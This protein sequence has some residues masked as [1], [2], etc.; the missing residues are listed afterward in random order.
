MHF[1]IIEVLTNSDEAK[2]LREIKKAEHEDYYNRVHEALCNLYD[3]Y[4]MIEEAPASTDEQKRLVNILDNA[5]T[6]F[7]KLKQAISVSSQS[8]QFQET[9]KKITQKLMTIQD[10]ITKINPEQV[11]PVISSQKT[12][13]SDHSE[14]QYQELLS[15]FSEYI[16][17]L[18]CSTSDQPAIG[19]IDNRMQ[20]TF[21]GIGGKKTI[22]DPENKYVIDLY[23][24]ALN[25]PSIGAAFRIIEAC[26]DWHLHV[27]KETGRDFFN[28]L[29]I[30]FMIIKNKD[31][32]NIDQT[33][34]DIAKIRGVSTDLFSR[35][36]QMLCSIVDIFNFD[37]SAIRERS[38]SSPTATVSPKTP[39]PRERGMTGIFSSLW[40]KP[41]EHKPKAPAPSPKT[42]SFAEKFVLLSTGSTTIRKFLDILRPLEM[43][44]PSDFG[45][46]DMNDCKQAIKN[47]RKIKGTC[48]QVITKHHKYD[49][50]TNPYKSILATTNRLLYGLEEKVNMLTQLQHNALT[51][52]QL[53][54]SSIPEL[55]L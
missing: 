25:K 52:E 14:S 24:T 27:K 21:P 50:V 7:N 54:S 49:N 43:D 45:A 10:A 11:K 30:K 38:S 1:E 9:L 22:L 34:S 46:Y 2:T 15:G 4:M 23:L 53:R 47:L 13:F 51:S 3:T 17:D 40:K 26:I 19:Y 12:D 32:K 55:T 6:N 5:N 29:L 8:R 37:I 18:D 20:H 39:I 16:E 31:G 41:A 44:E 33:C 35:N 36:I 42:S 28:Q 48:D